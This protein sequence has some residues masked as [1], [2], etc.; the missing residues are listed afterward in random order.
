M[1]VTCTV[2]VYSVTPPSLSRI[3]P[4]TVRVPVS[5]VGHEIED[6]EPNAP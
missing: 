1:T 4:C 6:D 2:A 3:L 5:S